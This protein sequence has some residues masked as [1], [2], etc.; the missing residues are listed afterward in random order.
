MTYY[1]ALILIPLALLALF[2]TLVAYEGKVGRRVLLPGRR[3]Q[4]DI[5]VARATFVVQ[6]VDWGAFANDVLRTGTERVLHD[7]AHMTLIVVR[8]IERQLTT[9]VRSLRER[10]EGLLFPVRNDDRPSRLESAVTYLKKS[11]YH[12]RKLPVSKEETE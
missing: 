11:V 10:R 8:A 9:V 7:L 1:I 6:H 5:K 2:L 12:S 3:H 4:L